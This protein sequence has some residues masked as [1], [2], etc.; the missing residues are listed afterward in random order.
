MIASSASIFASSTRSTPP[1]PITQGTPTYSPF[2]PYSPSSRQAQGSTRF[3]SLRKAS[4]ISMAESAGET[5]AEPV[6]SS[7]T[8]SP[9]AF[10]VRSTMASSFA[11][12]SRCCTGMPATVQ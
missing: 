2:T 8:T 12:E 5:K 11:L 4:A 1:A 3:L 10:L 9:P 7:A 6:L